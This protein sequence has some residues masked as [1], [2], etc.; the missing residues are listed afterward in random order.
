MHQLATETH[1][2]TKEMLQNERSLDDVMTSF[3]KWVGDC[4]NLVAHNA[5]F[6]ISKE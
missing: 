1:G 2:M 5:A 4:R 6:D 3:L